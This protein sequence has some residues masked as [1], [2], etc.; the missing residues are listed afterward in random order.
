MA[1]ST[2]SDAFIDSLLLSIE[3]IAE[4]SCEDMVAQTRQTAMP[5]SILVLPLEITGPV[6]AFVILVRIIPTP[7]TQSDA[8]RIIM[9]SLSLIQLFM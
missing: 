7:V 5:T 2:N 8:A 3:L 1:A 6:K 9:M 4:I